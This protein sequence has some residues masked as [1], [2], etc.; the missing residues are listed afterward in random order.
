M[1]I[2]LGEVTNR[3]LAFIAMPT[4]KPILFFEVRLVLD[5]LFL[6]NTYVFVE[7]NFPNKLKLLT[8]TKI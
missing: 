3:W 4:C 5:K 7:T 6:S 8:D 1:N 2:T